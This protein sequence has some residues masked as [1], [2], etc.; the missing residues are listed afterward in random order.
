[1]IIPSYISYKGGLNNFLKCTLKVYMIII[2]N[3]YS[4][5]AFQIKCF[6]LFFTP[7]ALAENKL[8][9]KESYQK[10]IYMYIAFQFLVGLFSCLKHT[11]IS[12]KKD[13]KFNLKIYIT[14]H[15]KKKLF[16][17]LFFYHSI[18]L[19]LYTRPVCDRF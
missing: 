12:F 10:T 11:F 2:H 7:Q 4:I 16:D 17:I 14:I 13:K 3:D 18:C 8:F 9:K 5:L 1:M 6:C 19:T 15:F